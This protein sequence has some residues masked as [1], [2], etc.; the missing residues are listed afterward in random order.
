MIIIKENIDDIDKK[1]KEL[2]LSRYKDYFSSEESYQIYLRIYI[3]R[4]KNAFFLLKYRKHT[5]VFMAIVDR[6]DRYRHLQEKAFKFLEDFGEKYKF[7]NIYSTGRI[8]T[9]T[10]NLRRDIFLFDEFIK[11]AER[12]KLSLSKRTVTGRKRL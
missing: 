10:S 6:V 12:F 1:T 4:D 8:E 9:D 3:Y 2:F 7:K 11:K 5:I